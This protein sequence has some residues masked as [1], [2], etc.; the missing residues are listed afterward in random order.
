MLETLDE[1]THRRRS[2]R[3]RHRLCTAARRHTVAAAAPQEDAP[4]ALRRTHT[5]LWRTRTVPRR[6]RTVS[7]SP[8]HRSLRIP[9]RNTS[10]QRCQVCEDC[11]WVGAC[12]TCRVAAAGRVAG[13][14]P[15]RRLLL[16][17]RLTCVTLR[18]LR[19]VARR[20][21]GLR[22]CRRWPSPRRR[23][24]ERV[25]V[26]LHARRS[27]V[28]Y[29]AEIASLRLKV[30]WACSLTDD[31]VEARARRPD[32]VIFAPPLSTYTRLIDPRCKQCIALVHI[33]RSSAGNALV[34]AQ[35]RRAAH[36]RPSRR[37]AT[38]RAA[39]APAG[40]ACRTTRRRRQSCSRCPA[41]CCCMRPLQTVSSTFSTAG[42]IEKGP[43]LKLRPGVGLFW[44]KL[45]L[46][47]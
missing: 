21:A 1:A 23:P 36:G 10:D 20:I 3:I 2:A 32:A 12:S 18:R 38:R 47:F 28:R 45:G 6:T 17:R 5:A 9:D 26:R 39:A 35:P 8:V 13:L 15:V 27:R 4:W 30:A 34:A 43:E 19:A 11:T 14:R 16:L 46:P 37:T 41:A 44:M 25:G 29:E 31:R 40:T 24:R 7:H 33:S 22:G 42:V